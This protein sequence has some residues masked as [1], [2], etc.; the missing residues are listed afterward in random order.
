MTRPLLLV[1]C[2]STMTAPTVLG[3]CKR[4][5]TGSSAD[6]G[7]VSAASANASDDV[8]VPPASPINATPVAAFLDAGDLE[9]KPPLERARA[10]EATGQ[11]WLARLILEKKAFSPDGTR[12]EAELLA[13]LCAAQEDAACVE[14]CG[15]KLGRKLSIDAGAHPS[16]V[17]DAGVHREPTGGVARAR[18]LVLKKQYDEARALLEPR[19]LDGTASKEEVRLLDT[20]CAQQGD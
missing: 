17:P 3:G 7:A 11:F 5:S 16:S 18:D 12:E 13:R 14:A 6:G 4:G 2:V 8:P 19:V 9:G 15:E 1:V 10:Y 20:V